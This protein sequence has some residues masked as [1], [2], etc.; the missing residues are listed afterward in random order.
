MIDAKL[1]HRVFFFDGLTLEDA[2]NG[3]Q[4]FINENLVKLLYKLE[5]VENYASGLT[6]IF[7]NS[8]ELGIVPEIY[9]SLY[10]FKVTLPNKNYEGLYLNP[11]KHIEDNKVKSNGR[12]NSDIN[13]EHFQLEN[14][15]DIEILEIIRDNPGIR[16]KEI[17]PK[18]KSKYPSINSN[19]IYKRIKILDSY[20][21]FRGIPKKGG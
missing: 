7:Q 2:L 14:Q 21:E 20:I 6:R 10:M 15:K 18:L 1:F 13:E 5:Y 16:L 9:T 17:A 8:K 12:V 4:S 19:I 3:L 11:E